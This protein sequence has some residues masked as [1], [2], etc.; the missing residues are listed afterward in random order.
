MIVDRKNTL[1]IILIVLLAVGN[2]FFATLY[3]S[4]KAQAEKIRQ[5]LE[6]QQMNTQV[7]SFTQL[8][9]DKVLK[10]K[11]EVS[12]EDRLKL[13]NA[14]RDLKDPQILSLWENFTESAIQDQAQESV[15]N[16]LDALVRKIAK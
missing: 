4:V 7:I 10:S 15:K 9:I 6:K 13:E 3:F 11:T 5:G 2:I 12:F 8:F 1:V 16:L 14:V